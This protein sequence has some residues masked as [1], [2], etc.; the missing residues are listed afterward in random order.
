M[1]LPIHQ[2]YLLYTHITSCTP[3][4]PPVHTYHLL[5]TKSTSCNTY[6]FLYIISTSCTHISLPINQSISCTHISLP[7]SHASILIVKRQFSF[8]YSTE[9]LSPSC[10]PIRS[11]FPAQSSLLL[12]TIVANL[13]DQ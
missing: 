6:H 10:L 5:C 4:L 11:T 1:S 2:I 13:S 7:T 12:V 9:I 8:G 3:N